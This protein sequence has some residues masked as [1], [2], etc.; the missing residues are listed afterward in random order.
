MREVFVNAD[1]WVARVDP[2]DRLHARALTATKELRDE[3]TLEEIMLVST[4]GV[5]AEALAHVSAGGPGLQRAMARLLDSRIDDQ[6][7]RVLFSTAARLRRAIELYEQRLG[8]FAS[9]HDCISLAIVEERGIVDALTYDTDFRDLG[10]R[11]LLR[12]D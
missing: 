2:R 8:Q 5:F 11:C 6:G 4:D 7:L 12:D 10:C 1:Y 9:L 3:A